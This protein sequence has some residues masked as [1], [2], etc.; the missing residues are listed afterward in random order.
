MSKNKKKQVAP[1]KKNALT[2][3]LMG[4][5]LDSKEVIDHFPKLLFVCFLM[6][7]YLVYDFRMEKETIFLQK[8]EKKVHYLETEVIVFE[9][10]LSAAQTRT[11]ISEQLKKKK[12]QL[13]S[14]FSPP[15]QLVF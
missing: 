13:I 12:I 10:A 5:F 3:L 6:I 2:T 15:R 9:A 4:H 11:Q 8:L 7:V 1:V 14:D